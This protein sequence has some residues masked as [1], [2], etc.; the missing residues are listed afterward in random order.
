M[1]THSPFLGVF[2]LMER[3][4]NVYLTSKH[5]GYEHQKCD[6]RLCS[7]SIHRVKAIVISTLCKSVIARES[8]EHFSVARRVLMCVRAV[9]RFLLP[10]LPFVTY[11]TRKRCF[12]VCGISICFLGMVRPSLLLLLD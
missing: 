2:L 12:P 6:A 1:D 10:S 5:I 7:M 11:P 4:S 8:N 9:N 3:S